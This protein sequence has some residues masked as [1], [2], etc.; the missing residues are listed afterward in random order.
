VANKV[1]TIWY[2]EAVLSG[3]GFAAEFDLLSNN[4]EIKLKSIDIN[5]QFTDA[6]VIIPEDSNT[7]INWNLSLGAVGSQIA[8]P[9]TN[10]VGA[11]P[12]SSGDRLFFYRSGQHF[13]NSFFIRNN[14]RFF[15]TLFNNSAN[16]ISATF[17]ITVETEENI[18]YQ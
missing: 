10:F 13:F 16:A 14:T 12:Q 6:A 17:S 9:F 1:Y 11:A 8:L 15:L 18:I 3:F 2:S 5:L 4:R 7:N